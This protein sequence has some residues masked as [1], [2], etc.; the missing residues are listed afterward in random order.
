MPGPFTVVI[1]YSKNYFTFEV[2]VPEFLMPYSPSCGVMELCLNNLKGQTPPWLSVWSLTSGAVLLW[3]HQRAE[4]LS[5]GKAAFTFYVSWVFH[6]SLQRW[7]QLCRWTRNLAAASKESKTTVSPQYQL[8]VNYRIRRTHSQILIRQL[9]LFIYS[10]NNRHV[11][12]LPSLLKKSPQD[13]PPQHSLQITRSAFF[14]SLPHLV[15]SL[16]VSPV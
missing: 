13:P 1:F 12:R 3:S 9:E 15:F 16:T 4:H 2:L 14:I 7:F 6:T 10:K 8:T 5:K 11:H